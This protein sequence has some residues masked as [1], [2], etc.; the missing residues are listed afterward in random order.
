MALT[1]VGTHRGLVNPVAGAGVLCRRAGVPYFLDACQSLGQLP[2]DVAE[3]GCDVATGTGRKWLR[4]PRGTGLLYVRT[5]LAEQMAPPG[6][7]WSAALWEDASHYRLRPGTA[8]F[9]EFEIPVA[10]HLALGTAIDHALAL[11]LEAIAERVGWLAE[12][13]RATLSALAGVAIHDG[14]VQRSG[15]VTFTVEGVVPTAV[16]EAAAAAGVNVSASDASMYR[17][18]LDAPNPTSRVRASP[19]YYNTEEELSGLVEVVD[20][21]TR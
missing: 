12:H 10:A 17:L 11:G 5:E 15:I 4:G 19:H 14:G 13:L 18:D 6:I 3:I 8:R 1:H 16:V 21:L 7:G 9:A 2:V 20:T